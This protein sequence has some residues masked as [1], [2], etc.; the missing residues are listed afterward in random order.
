MDREA[1]IEVMNYMAH[2]CVCG[3]MESMHLRVSGGCRGKKCGCT[4]F[5]NVYYLIWRQ[6]VIAA[7]TLDLADA[8]ERLASRM[9][10]AIGMDVEK[11]LL[12]RRAK[13]AMDEV[14]VRLA[15]GDRKLD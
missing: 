13:S 15:G 7:E 9:E 8:V 2:P 1:Q 14:R 10:A 4:E 3:H 5:S 11:S 6:Q 12:F